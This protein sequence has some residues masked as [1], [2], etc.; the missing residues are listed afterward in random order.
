V[1]FPVDHISDQEKKKKRSKQKGHNT[2]QY[3]PEYS[4]QIKDSGV[5]TVYPH[6]VTAPR[7][8]EI[9]EK[10]R[11]PRSLVKL[12]ISLNCIVSFKKPIDGWTINGEAVCLV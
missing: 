12:L 1:P 2:L 8:Y 3:Y 10:G 9:S 5:L 11:K 7:S 4:T 6:I